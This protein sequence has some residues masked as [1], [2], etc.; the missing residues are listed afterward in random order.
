MVKGLNLLQQRLAEQILIIDGGMGT[1]IQGYK[2]TESDYRGERFANWHCDI[3]GNNNLLVLTQPQIITDIHQQY[4]A[5]G[6]DILETNTFNA[7]TIAMADYDMA[8][9]VLK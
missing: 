9:L 6:A 4:L 7:T 3:K 8:D 2:L 1:M 5:A